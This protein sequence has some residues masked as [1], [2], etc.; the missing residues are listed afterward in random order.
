M[1]APVLLRAQRARHPRRPGLQFGRALSSA[2]ATAVAILSFSYLPVAESTAIGFV[3]PVIVTAMAALFL[4]EAVGRHRWC[5]AVVGL[6]GV[7]IIVRR[8]PTPS[9]SPR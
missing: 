2:L 8:G 5:A 4:G 1:T 3:A 6:V 7:V 9:G